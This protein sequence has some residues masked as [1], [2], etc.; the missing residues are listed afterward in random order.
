MYFQC[1]SLLNEDPFEV[2]NPQLVTGQFFGA[3]AKVS[4]LSRH[5]FA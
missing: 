2:P 1:T 4:Q 3:A 5:W